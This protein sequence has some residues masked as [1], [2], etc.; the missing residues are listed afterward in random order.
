MI[1]EL[2][3]KLQE[4]KLSEQEENKLYQEINKAKAIIEDNREERKVLNNKLAILQA[5]EK[6]MNKYNELDNRILS[7]RK[8]LDKANAKYGLVALMYGL[9]M[10]GSCVALSSLS[11]GLTI[12]FVLR[13]LISIS[14]VVLGLGLLYPVSKF[15]SKKIWKIEDQIKKLDRE[16][17]SLLDEV[18]FESNHRLNNVIDRCDA[19]SSKL[20]NNTDR[21][22]ELPTELIE[23]SNIET[24]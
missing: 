4:Q 19:I 1:E 11:L 3:K 21:H 18:Y 15:M 22:E 7:K 8:Q 24:F 12:S 16:K 17:M 20:N 14:P 5:D 6:R 9:L 13:L 2:I 23:E 10:A